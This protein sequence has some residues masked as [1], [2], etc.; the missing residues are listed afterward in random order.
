MSPL[1]RQAIA[2]PLEAI[3][4]EHLAQ[5]VVSVIVERHH[6]A[7]EILLQIRAKAEAGPFR[8]LLELPQGRLRT[9]E[10]L[11]AGAGRE[12][13]EETGL[14]A[15]TPR[16]VRLESA[17][18]EAIESLLTLTVR[19]I[20]HHD[21]LAVCLVGTATGRPRATAEAAEPRWYGQEATEELLAESRVFPLNVPMLRWYWETAAIS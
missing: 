15:F 17:R 7:R 4:R 16:G 3:V 5:P 11:V 9:G 14:T 18:G 13:E 10:S 8:G 12:L 6:P 1:S 2:H 19:D 21:F 20:G